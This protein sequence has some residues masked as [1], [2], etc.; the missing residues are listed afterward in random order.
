ML[1]LNTVH[2]FLLSIDKSWPIELTGQ[3]LSFHTERSIVYRDTFTLEVGDLETKETSIHFREELFE[4][5]N[6]V[7][8]PQNRYCCTSKKTA[9]RL[10]D[11]GNVDCHGSWCYTFQFSSTNGT[12]K[13]PTF[14]PFRWIGEIRK[15]RKF[16][17]PTAESK[18]ENA[19]L[20]LSRSH[21]R[22][23]KTVETIALDP[24]FFTLSTL[25]P[26]FFTLWGWSVQGVYQWSA[27]RI[28]WIFQNA[29]S[30]LIRI[31]ELGYW[32]PKQKKPNS[33]SMASFKDIVLLPFGKVNPSGTE[34]TLLKVDDA[35]VT[36][37]ETFFQEPETISSC[38]PEGFAVYVRRCFTLASCGILRPLVPHVFHVEYAST[39][40]TEPFAH[41][42][43]NPIICHGRIQHPSAELWLPESLDLA[44]HFSRSRF[45]SILFTYCV[46]SSRSILP[47]R[48]SAK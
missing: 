22:N 20:L 30:M 45:D 15:G 13:P 36:V 17:A 44:P 9:F 10:P 18:D 1:V 43:A 35:S 29:P 39:S 46:I 14:H 7:L 5:R 2:S 6:L 24:A 26:A 40:I 48:T 32:D 28:V 41:Y 27:D 47:M 19:S 12:T 8:A 11:I 16:E 34:E 42:Y 37:G 31:L 23:P 4:F 33:F 3:I 25:D 21:L 38:H